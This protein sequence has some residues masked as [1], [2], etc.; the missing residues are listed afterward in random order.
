MSRVEVFADCV[1][2]AVRLVEARCAEALIGVQIGIDDVPLV[3]RHT[4]AVPLALAVEAR[5]ASPAQVILYRRPLELR[6][7]SKAGLRKLVHR[8]LVEQLATVTARTVWEL[9]G[10]DL[11]DQA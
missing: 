2:A 8:V 7:N 10:D 5:Q 3:T 1:E 6:A 4:E 11:D 9:A